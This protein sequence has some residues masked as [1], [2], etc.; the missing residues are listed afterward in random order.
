MQQENDRHGEN[1][2]QHGL[3]PEALD[4]VIDRAEQERQN[5]EIEAKATLIKPS[6]PASRADADHHTGFKPKNQEISID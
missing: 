5:I 2:K 3:A 1:E 4:E 6:T